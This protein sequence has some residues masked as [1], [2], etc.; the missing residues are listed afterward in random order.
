MIRPADRPFKGCKYDLTA[1]KLYNSETF[2]V[3]H[4]IQLTHS[5]INSQEKIFLLRDINWT[6]NLLYSAKLASTFIHQIYSLGFN[7]DS[8]NFEATASLAP[9][10]WPA[11]MT[12]FPEYNPFLRPRTMS[13]LGSDC[14]APLEELKTHGSP[15]SLCQCCDNKQLTRQIEHVIEWLTKELVKLN[16]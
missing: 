6:I 9:A 4:T 11:K 8:L 5:T 16:V 12:R 3:N 7:K 14:T 15:L 13:E 2:H 1:P 10:S